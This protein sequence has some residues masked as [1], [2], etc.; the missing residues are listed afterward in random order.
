MDT[1]EKRGPGKPPIIKTA[2]EMQDKINEYF[3]SCEVEYLKEKDEDGHDKVVVCRGKPVVLKHNK[4]SVAG[5]AYHLGYKSRQSIYDNADKEQFSYIIERAKLWIEKELIS[6]AMDENVPQAV[7]I[8]LLK[9]FGYSDKVDINHTG[10]LHI[11]AP[12]KPE[13]AVFP[14]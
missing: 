9:Q 10:D 11:G 14:E 7:A 6:N 1:E 12:P 2:E 3:D 13:D 4:P 5:L 8:F